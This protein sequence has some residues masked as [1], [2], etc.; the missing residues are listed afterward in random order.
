MI[1]ALVIMNSFAPNNTCAAI[2]NTKLGKYLARED[3]RI[4]LITNEISPFMNIDENLVP[5]E[6]KKMRVI[7]VPHSKLYNRTLGSTREKMTN[8]GV[9]LKMKSE[10]RPL[11]ARIVSLIK[12]TFFRLRSRDWYKCAKKVV[13]RELKNE[14]FDVIYSTYPGAQAHLLAMHLKKKGVSKKWIADFRDPMCYTEY[15]R[16]RYR[17]S[18]RKQHR[19]ERFADAVTIVS[20]GAMEKFRW[21][22]VPESKITYI[23]NGFDHD[24]FDVGMMAKQAEAGKLRIFYAGT[25][26][27]GRRDLTVMFRAISELAAEGKL[28]ADKVSIEYAGNEWPVMLGFAESFGLGG[29]CTNYGF[30]TRHRVMEIMSE[31]DCSIVC[32]HNTKGDKGVVT[33]KVFEL[34]LV[35]KPIITVITGD[36]PDSELGAIVRDCNAGIVY[37]QANGETDYIAFKSWLKE[38]YDEKMCGGSVKSGLNVEEREKYFYGNIAH[39]L[40]GIMKKVSEN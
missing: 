2:P 10:K 19:I 28:D 14:K 32:S 13:R 16:F 11:R 25:L 35:G 23:P 30:V 40:Y 27:S 17:R 20:E 6:M 9:K 33:G 31:I 38:K 36:E 1:S 24:D 39:E 26:Y 18:M 8:S 21:D 3:V 7:Y 29:I 15:D 34:L 5:E 12:N 37:E 22:D 4:T